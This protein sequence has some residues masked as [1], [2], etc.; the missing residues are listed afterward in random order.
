M[1]ENS[2]VQVLTLAQLKAGQSA[3]V[4]LLTNPGSGRNREGGGKL[5]AILAR[6]PETI[7]E[8]AN[9][10]AEVHAALQRLALQEPEVLV[11]N[12]GDGTVAATF[13]ALF[14]ERP[15][16]RLPLLALL[17]G[18]T[19]NMTAADTGMKGSASRAL[20]R[21]LQWARA[22]DPTVTA[23]QRPVL[24]VQAGDDEAPLYGMF[25]G[26][27]AI[28]KGIEYCHQKILRRGLRDGYGPGLCMLR[29]LFALMRGDHRYV[30]P[31]ALKVASSPV[32]EES[33]AER[34]Y[35]ILLASTLERLF[36]G[37][38]PYWGEQ[39]GGLY[40]S[41]IGASPRR[42]LR[43]IP[44]LFW[45]KPGRHAT[46]ENGYW[47]RKIDELVLEL[48]GTFTIDGELYPASLAR[49][50]V[51]VSHTVPLTFLRF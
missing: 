36:L 28:I 46:P 10:P 24:R 39:N 9:T 23:V 34:K 11:I 42:P 14:N 41:A 21:L 29:I 35:F 25:F 50:L 37:M 3:R 13:T 44:P 40:Y 16:R 51:R 26:T 19:T 33:G 47:S 43:A 49:G 6:H 7:K 1:M 22:V 48:E 31:V 4:A 17:A 5:E 20:E 30:A 18:G 27:G 32:L 8:T 45:G 38:R 2:G 15:F 12:G